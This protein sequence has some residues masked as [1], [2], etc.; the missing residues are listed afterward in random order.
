MRYVLALLLPAVL[1]ADEFDTR[2][3]LERARLADELAAYAKWSGNKALKGS[4]DRA[5]ET[6]LIF[7]PDHKRA[8]RTLKYRWDK[9]TDSWGR[10]A[11]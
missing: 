3:S 7:E 1:A 5:Y 10:T 6:L 9:Q 11:A 2:Y 4:R 8:R